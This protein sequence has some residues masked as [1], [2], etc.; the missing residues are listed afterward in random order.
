MLVFMS[1]D[2]KD[3]VFDG[4]PYF[5]VVVGLYMRPW[6]MNIVGELERFTFVLIW[7]ILYSIPLYY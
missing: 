1:L 3:K 7:I 5:Y 4:A 6:V 2:D